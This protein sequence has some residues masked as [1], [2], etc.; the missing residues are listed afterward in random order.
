VLFQ[1]RQLLLIFNDYVSRILSNAKPDEAED[2]DRSL[3]A[4]NGT[5]IWVRPPKWAQRAVFYRDRGRCVLC[6]RDLTGLANL[7][8]L[9]NYDHIVSL[10]QFGLNDI[11]NLQLLCAHCNQVEKRDG[12]ATTSARYQSWYSMGD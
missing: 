10:A 12:D 1:N 6:D 9:E 5:L 3:L 4:P 11:T 8:N 2:L 7:D